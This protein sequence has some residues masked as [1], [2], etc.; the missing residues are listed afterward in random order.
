MQNKASGTALECLK[1]YEAWA[2]YGGQYRIKRL[3]TDNGGECT[4]G[5]FKGYLKSGGIRHEVTVPHSPQQNGVTEHMNRTLQ[6]MALAILS[7]AEL[8]KRF[9]GETLQCASYIRN[10]LP[11]AS[12]SVTPYEWWHGR[13]P[14]LKHMKV[15]G[16]VGYMLKP[17][18]ART[19]FDSKS[20]KMHF[21][22]YVPNGY[23]VYDEK[24]NLVYI[25]RNVMFNESQFSMESTSEGPRDPGLVWNSERVGAPEVQNEV[26]AELEQ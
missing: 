24:T 2:S 26:P 10:R 11:T 16:C 19:K 6:E 17:E 21:M 1:D 3:R 9:W 7:Q 25:R 18:Q 22:G 14:G 13:K 5:L 23:R 15:F 4:L 8:P 20:N 12:H